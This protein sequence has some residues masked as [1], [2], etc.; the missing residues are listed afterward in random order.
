MANAVGG[1]ERQSTGKWLGWRYGHS[2]HRQRG[3]S[4]SL[5]SHGDNLSAEWE[6]RDPSA[7]VEKEK[8][9][10]CVCRWGKYVGEE[11]G[12][13]FYLKGRCPLTWDGESVPQTGHILDFDVLPENVA[14]DKT[15]GRHL[16]QFALTFGGLTCVKSSI[17]NIYLPPQRVMLPTFSWSFAETFREMDNLSQQ[18]YTFHLRSKKVPHCFISA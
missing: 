2:R 17:S 3:S 7:S 12:W 9:T 8:H 4:G 10:C 15:S 18:K 5:L 11:R 13:L 1:T 6:A 16:R 14:G